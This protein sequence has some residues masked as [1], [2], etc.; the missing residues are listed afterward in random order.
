MPR[1]RPR[2]K[3]E[4]A[5]WLA[6]YIGQT[7]NKPESSIDPNAE[8]PDLGVDSANVVSL[9]CAAE[10]WVGTDL[11]AGRFFEHPTV[12]GIASYLAEQQPPDSVRR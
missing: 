2:T 4:A 7:I 12:D 3:G 1:K 8:L 9:L 10:R 11:Y 6:R 5:D